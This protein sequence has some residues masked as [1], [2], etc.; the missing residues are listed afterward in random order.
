[1][2]RLET[3]I[4]SLYNH[5]RVAF[6]WIY[7]ICG[8]CMGPSTMCHRR[9]HTSADGKKLVCCTSSTTQHNS[10]TDSFTEMSDL[11][12]VEGS[13]QKPTI[14]RVLS[15]LTHGFRSATPKPAE[16]SRRRSKAEPTKTPLVSMQPRGDR[17][18]QKG[19][20]SLILIVAQPLRKACC[21]LK[22]SA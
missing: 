10:M 18:P 12:D 5:S 11:E 15:E 6:A 16:R 17:C 1:M 14:R 7:S 2:S 21:R 3:G 19:Q 4:R 13:P 9:Q 20:R 8:P 22:V